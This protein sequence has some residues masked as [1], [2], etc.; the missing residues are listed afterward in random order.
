MNIQLRII[1]LIVLLFFSSL[2]SGSEAAYFSLRRWRLARLIKEECGW[3]KQAANLLSDPWK[4]LMT[5]LLGNDMVNIIISNI[6]ADLRRELLAPYGNWPI[7]LSALCTLLIILLLGEVLPKVIAVSYAEEFTRFT[8]PL[9]HSFYFIVT[10]LTYP[11]V[12]VL[13][14]FSS[15]FYRTESLQKKM[16]EEE[17]KA[18]LRLGQQE[19]SLSYY[20][21]NAIE[22]IFNFSQ[23]PIKYIMQARAQ[24]PALPYNYGFKKAVAFM[25]KYKLSYAP[26]YK[27][28]YDDIIGILTAGNAVKRLL[29]LVEHKN[30]A[31][32]LEQP[33]FVPQSLTIA[34]LLSQIEKSMV[35]VA[36]LVDEYG[37]VAGIIDR[38][39]I[40]QNLMDQLD[41][42]SM[43]LPGIEKLSDGRY[44]VD[45]RIPLFKLNKF[46]KREIGDSLANTLAGHVLN[47]FGHIPRKGESI[48]ADRFIYTVAEMEENRLKKV[49]IKP[50]YKESKTKKDDGETAS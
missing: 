13:K 47:L 16:E 38:K 33:Q 24:M 10:P 19:G 9:V 41:S 28:S 4:L 48:A 42:S 43:L 20:E 32:L 8:A 26:V 12:K 27:E 36:L 1:I 50:Q 45:A 22:T 18:L 46:L 29:G 30:I 6:A 44:A 5:I 31:D 23:T 37:G 7:F 11:V 2:F 35:D 39:M 15:F 14:K 49:I 3:A 17:I 25:K 34:E 21:V 40:F